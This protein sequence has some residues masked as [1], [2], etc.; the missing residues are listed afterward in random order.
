MVN[1]LTMRGKNFDFEQFRLLNQGVRSV[2]SGGRIS[3]MGDILDQYGKVI[4]SHD[5]IYREWVA[6]QENQTVR[7][8]N[9]KTLNDDL[10]TEKK[11]SRKLPEPQHKVHQQVQPQPQPIPEVEPKNNVKKPRRM[12]EA[13]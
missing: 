13:N 11:P 7:K 2:G 8:S 3:V 6:R 4:K 9:I 5:D 1:R 12:V 10:L